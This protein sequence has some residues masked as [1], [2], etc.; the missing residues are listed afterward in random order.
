MF[1]VGACLW[2]CADY[3]SP[4]SSV[5]SGSLSVVLC[6]LYLPREQCSQWE[7]VCGTVLTIS[8][9]RAV[10]SVGACL[11]YCADY[12]SPEISVLSGSLSVV[13]C[14]LYF[15][16][17]QCS[18]WEPVC[19]TVLT[20]FPQRVVFSV[21]ACL[22][23]CADYISPEISVLSG[24]LS[25]VLCWLYFPREQCS[26]WEPVC[27]TVLTISPQ[28]AVF[29]VGACLWYCADY[30]S[31]E[32]SVLSGSLSVVLCW[33]Y[34]PRE[35]CSQWEPVCGTVLTISPQRAVFSVGACLWYCADYISPE[36]SVLSGSLSV[37][38][39]WLYLPREQCS[40]WE[41][42]CGT[43]LTISPQRVS[44]LSGS[45]SVVLCWLY[46][47]REQC[48]Q[49]EP[50]CG[51]V[52][53]IFPQRA[54]FSVGACL[55]Y[56][57]DYIS[58][59]SQCS[60]WEPVC[61]TVLTISPQ[62]AVFSVGACLWYCADYIS[63]ESSVLSGSLSVV[64]CWL[65]LPREQC[66]QWEPVCGTVL[67]IFPQRVVFSVGAC[68][69]YCADYISPESSVQCVCGSGSLSVVL[70]WLYFPREQCSQWEPVCGTV[71]TIFPQRVVFSVG[72][73]LWYCADYIS[74]ESSVLSG[75]LSVV[76]C[77]LYLPRE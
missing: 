41:P 75:S 64:L 13:L 5:L 28:R 74:P 37:V 24:S 66:S 6:W 10:F 59:E 22:W 11:W 43:V 27:G 62:R 20:I 4:E 1:S 21:G 57:A 60:Q 51:T 8:P 25:V 76:L 12:I 14:W 36:I 44:V 55:W 38:L 32:S 29:S 47:P 68:L 30:I 42:V 69:W 34:L 48:S 23:Y 39:C 73:C 56:C 72:A 52:L 46:L 58:P 71:L 53:T 70:C 45:L 33:L 31:P 54:V 49:W 2:Y 17:E 18:Q 35:Q 50:V 15:P 65:Y 40:Q 3:I 61:G 9:Q 26:Q 63:P 77:W 7:P 19:G 16:R 67:T